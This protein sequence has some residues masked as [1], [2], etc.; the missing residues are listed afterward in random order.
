MRVGVGNDDEESSE[1]PRT[2]RQCFVSLRLDQLVLHWV[3]Q[4]T[5]KVIF[6]RSLHPCASSS[7]AFVLRLSSLS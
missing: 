5:R 1:A 3:E 6:A 7:T 2:S 4:L